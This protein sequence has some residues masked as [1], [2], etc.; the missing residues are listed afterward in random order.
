MIAITN[1][2][3]KLDTPPITNEPEIADVEIPQVAIDICSI[4]FQAELFKIKGDNQ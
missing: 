1:N 4:L 3:P 2:Q